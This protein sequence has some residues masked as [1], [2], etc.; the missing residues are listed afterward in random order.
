MEHLTYS[1][2]FYSDRELL[3]YYNLDNV[4][5]YYDNKAFFDKVD[6]DQLKAE[7]D[8]NIKDIQFSNEFDDILKV[9]DKDNK[10]KHTDNFLK[11]LN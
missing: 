6:E 5:D 2:I 9:S 3:D 10:K 1:H 7:T 8:E 4:Q 11:L